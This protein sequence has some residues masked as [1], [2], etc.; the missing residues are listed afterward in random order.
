MLI[1][2]RRVRPGARR[3]RPAGSSASRRRPPRP[4]A[5]AD[6]AAR[7]SVAPEA[8]HRTP[9]R[10]VVKR[11]EDSGVPR[12]EDRIE[13]TDRSQE[14][15]DAM[16]RGLDLACSPSESG[17]PPT[18]ELN[19]MRGPTDPALRGLRRRGESDLEGPRKAKG[20]AADWYLY[21]VRR[22]EERRL[23]VRKGELP[24]SQRL[25]VR[26]R[27]GTRSRASTRAAKR[28]PRCGGSSAASPRSRD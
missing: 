22:D 18:S 1:W 19:A 24:A 26:A 7:R 14:A 17:P 23:V 13:V 27:P 2:P 3:C 5:V 15:L 28:R 20:R 9:Y 4:H 16:L 11:R 6:S 21:S 12:F 8:R 10:R 25:A